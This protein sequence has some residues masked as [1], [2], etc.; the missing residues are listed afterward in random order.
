VC[1]FLTRSI[2]V[3]TNLSST[4]AIVDRLTYR[5]H[6]IDSVR[7]C[8]RR[9]RENS[10]NPVLAHRTPLPTPVVVRRRH[11]KA[12]CRK[13]KYQVIPNW[14]CGTRHPSA[15]CT[16]PKRERLETDITRG[17]AKGTT[18]IEGRHKRLVCSFLT[19][20]RSTVSQETTDT[21]SQTS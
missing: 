10:P 18:P 19:F 21:L 8:E 20:A 17:C 2:V 3:T 11:T 13:S 15:I 6:I 9:K 16:A 14:V 12:S 4:R 1:S 5:A 7:L